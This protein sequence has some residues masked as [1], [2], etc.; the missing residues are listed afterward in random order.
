VAA[1]DDLVDFVR[2]ALSRKIPREQITDALRAGG[3]SGDQ[4]QTALGAYADAEFPIPVPRARPYLSARD[5]FVYLVLFGTLYTS[6]YNLG[7]LIFGFIDIAFPDAAAR[8]FENYDQVVRGRIRWSVASLIVAVPVFL[9]LS[10]LTGREIS[11]DPGKRASKVRRWLT[12][13]TL[14]VAACVLIGDVT[15][16]VYNLL[17]GELTVRFLLKVATVAAIAGTAFTYY[18]RDLR[19]D[20]VERRG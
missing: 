7:S 3:W 16:L 19:Q 5:A 17:G 1:G 20:E 6:A 4:I 10:W 13:L 12:Y 8:T 11:R 18:L 14:F 15:T 9:Y 2:E